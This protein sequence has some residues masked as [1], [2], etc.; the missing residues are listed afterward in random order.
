[1]LSLTKIPPIHSKYI[2]IDYES[3][4]LEIKTRLGGAII[5]SNQKY[6]SLLF[7]F[8]TN[9]ENLKR[10]NT[11]DYEFINFV[12]EHTNEIDDINTRLKKIHD[13]FRHVVEAVNSQ[14]LERFQTGKIKQWAWRR[15]PEFYDIAVTDIYLDNVNIA[16]DA[17]IDLD[18]WRFT[19]FTRKNKNEFDLEKYLQTRDIAYAFQSYNKLKL[20]K[21]FDIRENDVTVA[22]YIIQ[23]IEKLLEENS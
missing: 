10:G 11:M 18:G 7:D 23:I 13:D 3:L 8:I 21:G 2:F 16:I 19:I 12:K 17:R 4:F 22:N 5:R 1:V 6:L 20:D 15:L 9:I 14:I